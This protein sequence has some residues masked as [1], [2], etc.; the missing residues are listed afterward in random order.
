MEVCEVT[1]SSHLHGIPPQT[2]SNGPGTTAAIVTSIIVMIIFV[3]AVIRVIICYR[4]KMNEEVL[5]N[6][7]LMNQLPHQKWLSI[8]TNNLGSGSLKS[9]YSA[10]VRKC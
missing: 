7:I 3:I 5:G 2:I 10:K 4:R 8:K 9:T 6:E 1:L